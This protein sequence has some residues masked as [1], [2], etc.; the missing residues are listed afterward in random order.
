MT[1]AQQKTSRPLGLFLVVML[2]FGIITSLNGMAPLATYGLGAIFYL[3][4]AIVLFL[5]PAALV[6]SELGT[7]YQRDGGVYTWVSEAFGPTAGFVATWLQWLQNIIFWT[8]VLTGSA[9]MLAVSLGWTEGAE[10]RLY[11]AAVVLGTIW[12][13]TALSLFGLRS[14]GIIGTVGTIAGTILPG[15]L[16]IAFAVGYILDDQP[17]NLVGPAADLVPDLSNPANVTF[18]LA[19]ILVFA[20]IEVMAARIRDMR[21]PERTY[22]RATLISVLMIAALIVPA[23][24]AISILVPSDDIS[25]TAGIVQAM[26]AGVDHVWHLGWLVPL[27]AIA[28]YLDAIGEIAGWMAATP[29][30]MATAAREGHLPRKLAAEDARNTARPVLIGQA[31]VGS[32]ISLLFIFQPS[33]S[34]MFWLL[35]AL[36]VQLYVLMYAM[37]FAAALRLRRTQPDVPRPFR[38]PG[39]RPGIWFVCGIGIVFSAAAIIVGFIPPA[40][41]DEATAISHTIVLVAAVVLCTGAPMAIPRRE[42]ARSNPVPRGR[43]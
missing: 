14:S 1:A 33:V 16:L 34:S 13:I 43:Q 29:A 20:G 7:T 27:T 38:I 11:S 25:I 30:A 42:R 41:L 26:N 21:T 19:A 32:S 22:P 36:L 6:A 8:V 3:A 12:L 15:A 10:N 17:N 35:S 40:G 39:G 4:I 37:M 28:I 9:A 24:L 2:M 31:V 5:V 18:G 23:T